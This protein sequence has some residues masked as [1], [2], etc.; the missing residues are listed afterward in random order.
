MPDEYLGPVSW[1]AYLTYFIH[2]GVSQVG[3]S[4]L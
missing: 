4:V 2:N 3:P 1:D